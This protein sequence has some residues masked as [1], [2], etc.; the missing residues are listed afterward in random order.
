MR[1]FTKFTSLLV[2]ISLSGCTL[3]ENLRQGSPIDRVSY[4]SLQTF[5]FEGALIYYKD[6]SNPCD[7]A[8]VVWNDL[9]EVTP[10]KKVLL[11][12]IPIDC[13]EVAKEKQSLASA[14]FEVQ[15]EISISFETR[16]TELLDSSNA[17]RLDSMSDLATANTLFQIYGAAGTVGKRSEALG[18]ERASAVKTRLMSMGV[19]SERITIMPYDAKIPGLQALIKVLAPVVL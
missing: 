11:A 17:K 4:P 6:L 3:L 1:L 15:E 5:E 9:Q 16:K 12:A 18:L 19:Q 13:D 7:D 14:R 2:L 10:L 8:T